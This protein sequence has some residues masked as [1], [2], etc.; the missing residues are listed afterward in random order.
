MNEAKV[1]QHGVFA[2]ILSEDTADEKKVWRF[3]YEPSYSGPPISWTMP[4]T[5]PVY[6]F[7]TFPPFFEGLLPEGYQLE[8]LLRKA[9]LDRDDYFGQLVTVGGDLVGSVTVEL[10]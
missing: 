2:G 10:G 7:K 5:Q 6:V 3:T 4:R 1:Y 8:A 9:K